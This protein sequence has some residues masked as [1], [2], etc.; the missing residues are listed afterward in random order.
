MAD[1]LVSVTAGLSLIP[2]L[3]AEGAVLGSLLAVV[4]VSLPANLRALARVTDSTP[5]Q[6]ARSLWPWASRFL[7]VAG[8]CAVLSLRWPPPP[9]VGAL[10]MLAAAIGLIYSAVMA[11]A[12]W[13]SPLGVYARPRLM[14]YVPLRFRPAQASSSR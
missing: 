14:Q 3:G 6:I 4:T 12:L 8:G 1:G 9:T 7:L 5:G 13:H 2:V 11:H 10:S